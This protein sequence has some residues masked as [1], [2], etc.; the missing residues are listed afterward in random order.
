MA[1]REEDKKARRARQEVERRSKVTRGSG[2]NSV[3][4]SLNICVISSHFG[5]HARSD[6][7][8]T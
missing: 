2:S 7:I 4:H 6:G 1:D 5:N 3:N 8:E